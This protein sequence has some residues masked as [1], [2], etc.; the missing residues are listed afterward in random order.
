MTRSVI[1]MKRFT[2]Q[3]LII[4]RVTN[5]QSPDGSEYETDHI[6]NETTESHNAGLKK[7]HL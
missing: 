3:A 4:T 7:C 2:V 5:E 1:V 6:H